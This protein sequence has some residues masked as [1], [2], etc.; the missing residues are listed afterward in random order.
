MCLACDR[1]VLQDYFAMNPSCQECAQLRRGIS[2]PQCLRIAGI[3][4][5]TASN[6]SS[7]SLI[8]GLL[9]VDPTCLDPRKL[10]KFLIVALLLLLRM[11]LLI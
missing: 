3:P 11:F 5:A 6:Q 2:R 9:L 1:P 7:Q 8:T 4:T 10:P